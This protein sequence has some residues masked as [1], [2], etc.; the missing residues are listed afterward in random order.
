VSACVARI[1]GVRAGVPC[2][3]V[4]AFATVLRAWTFDPLLGAG[5]I[6]AAL[7]YGWAARRVSRR[8]PDRPWPRRYTVSFLSALAL[9]WIALLGPFGVYDDTF[10]WA[11]MVQH[12]TLMMLV[13]PL[14]LLGAPV[15]LILRVSSRHARRKWILPVL[16]SRALYALT[17]PVVGWVVFAATLVGTHFSPFYEYCITHPWAHE[18]LE[19]PVY[20][21]A[22]L[23][24]YYPL[25]PGNPGP[26]RVSPALRTAS[27]FSMMFPETMTGFFIYATGY[28]MFPYYLHV[29]RPFGP[30]PLRDQQWGGALM[31]S[32]SMLVDAVWVTIAACDWLR[33]ER[34]LARR[35]DIQTMRDMPLTTGRNA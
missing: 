8:S 6:I 9:A 32:G 17:N 20:L 34:E 30:P 2:P 23:I 7:A 24:Y 33:S 27:L 35:I 25:L 10:F 31:W 15:L 28:V 11:H 3:P 26:R 18:L 16:R 13:A 1:A 4:G 21:L 14:L 22:G 5:I 29:D 19:H 12:L